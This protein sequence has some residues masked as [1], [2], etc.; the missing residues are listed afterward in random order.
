MSYQSIEDR[1]PDRGRHVWR[2]LKD[3]SHKCVL[4]GGITIQ[5]PTDDCLCERYEEL[6]DEERDM[7]PQR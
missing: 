1:R 4:C 6:T 3:G 2:R 5:V 7:C